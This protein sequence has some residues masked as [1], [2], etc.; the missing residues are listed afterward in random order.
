MNPLS[1]CK[2][3]MSG[4]T[5]Y[6]DICRESSIT[7]SRLVRAR[8]APCKIVALPSRRQ[9]LHR[10]PSRQIAHPL[11]PRSQTNHDQSPLHLAPSPHLRHPSPTRRVPL[12]RH[13]RREQIQAPPALELPRS[14]RPCTPPHSRIRPIR[15]HP[16]HPRHHQR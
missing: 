9:R 3:D 10:F 13:H 1:V 11:K 6:L 15:H 2:G 8:G 16:P 12:P 4:R 5:E 14:H 7:R